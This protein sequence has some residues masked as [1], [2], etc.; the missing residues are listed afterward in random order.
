VVA[1]ALLVKGELAA[2]RDELYETLRSSPGSLAYLEIIGF[3]LTLLGD[4]EQGPALSRSALERNPHCLPHVQFGLWADHLRR[5][6]LEQAYQAALEY[7]DATFFWRPAMRASCLGLLGRIEEAQAEAAELLSC[8]PDF[9]DRGRILIGH[10]IK[11][12]DLFDRIVEGLPRAG[13][14]CR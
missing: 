4:W 3:L 5:G 13:V 1:G 8:K 6:E 7:R 14:S 9:R 11:F 12:P 2:G 10:Y